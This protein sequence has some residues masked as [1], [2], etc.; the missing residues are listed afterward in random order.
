MKYLLDTD[1]DRLTK[2]Y[3]EEFL[4]SLYDFV[5]INSVDDSPRMRTEENPFGPTVTQALNFIKDLAI[6]DGFK[7]TNYANKVVEIL[8]GEGEKN[9]TVLAHADVVPEGK[10]WPHHPFEVREI[11]GVLTG[12]G[13]ADDKGPLLETYYAIKALRDNNLLGNYQI[14]FIVG[15]NEESGSLGVEYYYHTLNKKQPDL[16]FSPDSDW[17]LIY[18]EKGIRNFKVKGHFVLDNVCS[19]DGGLA[20]NSVIEECVVRLYKKD[21]TLLELFEK[22]L[23]KENISVLPN[24]DGTFSIIVRG[25]S[26]HGSMPELGKN[27]AMLSLEVLNEYHQ[28]EN[29]EHILKCYK[30]VYARGINAYYESEKMDGQKTSMNIGIFHYERE[31]MEF[32]VNYRYVDTCDINEAFENIKKASAP[33][34]IEVLADSPLLYYDKNSTLISTLLKAYQEETGDLVS[35]PLA[36]GGGTYAKEASNVVAFGAQFPDW[37]S[38]MHGVLEGCRKEDMFKSMSIYARAI[39]L[40]G[41]ELEK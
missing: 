1:Y 39:V 17:P 16:G 15:G 29:L 41:K 24:H 23:G 7:A 30:D 9:L 4:K 32:V 40:L 12:R 35:K 14:K 5:A 19:I 31:K 27:A 21:L 3:H 37:D 13:V 11:D 36:I 8:I 26:A 18:A 22:R 6:K 25:K 20:S 10:G 34:E 38:H 33:F 2:P 28:D